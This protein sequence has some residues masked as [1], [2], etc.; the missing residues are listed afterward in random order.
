MPASSSLRRLL[1]SLAALPA[2]SLHEKTPYARRGL[3]RSH[4]SHKDCHDRHARGAAEPPEE[5]SDA[6]LE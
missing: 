4:G 5:L 2:Y 3:P 1:L 6:R